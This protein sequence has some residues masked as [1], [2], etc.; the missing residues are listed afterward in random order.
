MGTRTDFELEL[1]LIRSLEAGSKAV[2]EASMAA[3]ST[4]AMYLF[5]VAAAPLWVLKMQ[6]SAI[7]MSLGV[8][9]AAFR[10]T[11][12]PVKM[13][14]QACAVLLKTLTHSRRYPQGVIFAPTLR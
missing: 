13:A 10:S 1:S 6:M 5:E 2:G 12:A 7:R 4:F 3:L 9:A 8:T 11:L 14:M